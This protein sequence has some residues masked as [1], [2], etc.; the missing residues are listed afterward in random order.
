MNESL[1]NYMAVLTVYENNFRV[2]HWKLC[3]RDFHVTHSRFGDYYDE[4]GTFLDETAEQILSLG[5]T[6]VNSH[7]ALA[8]L[9]SSNT[10]V[11]VIDPSSDYSSEA[12]DTA[13]LQMFTTLYGMSSA[14]MSDS[15]IGQDVQDVFLQHS[16]YYRLEGFYKLKRAM[17]AS[18]TPSPAATTP[19]VTPVPAEELNE[20]H[21]HDDDHDAMEMDFD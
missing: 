13:A 4:M 5:G 14:L 21:D 9:E 6:P 1:R 11:I 10:N 18:G 15:S 12:A 19:V 20:E 17:C 3:G 8:M 16:K 7:E 2:L